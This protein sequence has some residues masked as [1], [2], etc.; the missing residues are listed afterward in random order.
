MVRGASFDLLL[1]ATGELRE[2]LKGDEAAL[3]RHM[4]SAAQ[5]TANYGKGIWRSRIRQAGMS[6]RLAKTVRGQVY[7]ER[8][9]SLTPAVNVFTKAPDIMRMH[10]EGTTIRSPGGAWLAI[11]TEHAP[12]QRGGR[13]ITPDQY[14]Q[15]FGAG[16]LDFV[17]VKPSRLGM[18]VNNDMRLSL[19][20]S[21]SGR[22]KKSTFKRR[23]AKSRQPRVAV[24]IYWLVR[25]VRGKKRL[26]LDA[27]RAAMVSVQYQTMTRAVSGA[28]AERDAEGSLGR[29][30]IGRSRSRKRSA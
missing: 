27:I 6:D 16:S 12:L 18:L 23:S 25:E 20:R 11:P 5:K 9:V 17:E 13:R 26:D 7:P 15:R 1:A 2:A 4:M 28:V 21:K 30:R 22:R 14:E 3:A 8:G 19:G 29:S 24:P 10:T